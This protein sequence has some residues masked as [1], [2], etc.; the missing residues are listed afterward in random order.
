MTEVERVDPNALFPSTRPKRVEVNT[1]HLN[2]AMPDSSTCALVLLAAGGST[3]MGRPKQLLPVHGQPLLRHVT[4]LAL[5]ASV[6]PVVVVLGANADVI[7]PCLDGLSVQIAV[8]PNW[9]EGLGSSL[10]CGMEALLTAVPETEVVIVALADQPALPPEHLAQL[11]ARYCQ[12]G[13]TAVASKIGQEPVPPVLFDRSWFDRLRTL[14]G[15][16]GARA[17]LHER[18]AE[19]ATVPLATNTDLDTPEDYRA[20]NAQT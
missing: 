5:R 7:A 13:C 12:G 19:V 3:R 16:T 14:T 6:S 17:L 15:D 11:I 20:F 2:S 9:S 10:R 1:L 4:Q 18:A 8:N